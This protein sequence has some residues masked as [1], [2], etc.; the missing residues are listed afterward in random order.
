MRLDGMNVVVCGGAIGGA[1]A[2]LLLARAGAR[3][4]LLEQVAAPRAVGAGIAVAENGAAVLEGLGLGD[5]IAR[6]RRVPGISV[7]DGRGRP[8]LAPPQPVP[9]ITMLRRA[10]LHEA[11]LDALAAT[12]GIEASFGVP[13]TRVDRV[14]AVTIRVGNHDE[15]LRADLIVGADGVHSVVRQAMHTAVS[16]KRSGIRYVR[17]LVAGVAPMETEAWTAA[18]IFGS[19][20]TDDGAY[21]YASCGTHR[22]RAAVEERSLERFRSE[23][24]AAYPAAESLLEAIPSWDALLVNEVVRVQCSRFVDGCIALVGDAAH[25]MAPNLGQGANSAL[26]DAAVLLD[27]LRRAASLED[28]LKAYDAR[29]R[30]VVQ[31]VA[32]LAARLGRLAEITQPVAR[33]A[34][35][36]L[37]LPVVERLTTAA[38]M[39]K[40]LQEDTATLAEISR[41]D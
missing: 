22:L 26:V 40:V 25:A 38:A 20:A 31:S 9:R 28:G 23:W 27:S 14:G 35:D 2:A 34:R 4:R 17:T 6:G 18:G 30:R 1:S 41:A 29:R 21:L 8:M 10:T 33:A 13:V 39:R 7:V 12:P 11:L 36:R 32:T 16:V 19:F 37:L 24:H 15:T 3:V 5:V